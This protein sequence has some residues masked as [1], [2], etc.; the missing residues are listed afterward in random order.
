[1]EMEASPSR[2]GSF[3]HGWL[4]CEARLDADADAVLGHSFCSS[5]SFI[6]M[7]PEELFS[8]R[9]TSSAAAAAEEGEEE[10]AEFDF[11]MP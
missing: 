10:D 8:M 7:D 3:S 5:S 4:R 11:G 2:S 6:D 9:W 1:M